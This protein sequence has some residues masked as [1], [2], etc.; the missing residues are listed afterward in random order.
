[1]WEQLRKIVKMKDYV[2]QLSKNV[3]RFFEPIVG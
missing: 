3:A 1:M 2:A